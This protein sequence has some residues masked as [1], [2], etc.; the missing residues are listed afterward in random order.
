MDNELRKQLEEFQEGQLT[1]NKE[2][3]RD[4]LLK[5]LE[6]DGCKDPEGLLTLFSN[7]VGDVNDS[8]SYEEYYVVREYKLKDIV[9][10][11]EFFGIEKKDWWK[12]EGEEEEPSTTLLE[13]LEN[14]V[15]EFSRGKI[16]EV[17]VVE[18]L[19]NISKYYIKNKP[20]PLAPNP[21]E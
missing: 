5:R 20:K 15:S 11:L 14:L 21:F 2:W 3:Q 18:V 6:E 9:E 12:E 16:S 7:R 13:D 10:N 4:I 17:D 8:I 1:E 19:G